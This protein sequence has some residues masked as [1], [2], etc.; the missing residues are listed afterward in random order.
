MNAD[1]FLKLAAHDA[2]ANREFVTAL[3][4]MPVPPQRAMELVPHIISAQWVWLTRMERKPQPMRVWPELSLAD[5]RKEVDKLE[6]E[7]KRFLPKANLDETF[8][9]TNTKGEHFES[10]VGDTL[11]HVFLHGHYH[12]GMIALL[13]RQTGVTPPYTDFIEAVR[14]AKI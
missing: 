12:R 9:Y 8:A 5:C 2:W 6:T 3:E 14:K 11:T 4:K 1:Y 13:I 7:W 10:R